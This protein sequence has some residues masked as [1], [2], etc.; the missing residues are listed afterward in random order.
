[1]KKYIIIIIGIVC[2]SSCG[3]ISKCGNNSGWR[4]SSIDTDEDMEVYSHQI[5]E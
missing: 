5:K 1:M 4:F 3:T 2:F